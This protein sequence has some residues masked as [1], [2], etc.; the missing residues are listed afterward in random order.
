MSLLPKISPAVGFGY[1]ANRREKM[2][3]LKQEYLKKLRI[4]L[5][6]KHE[7]SK[8][9]E[10]DRKIKV[11]KFLNFCES[12]GV[13][14]IQDI[15]EQHFR[16][17]IKTL[18]VSTETKRKYLLALRE[19]FDRAHLEIAINVSRNIKS[20]KIKKL[21]KMIQILNIDIDSITEQQKNELLKL[22]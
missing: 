20:T 13:Q 10:Y 2:G 1:R 22:L 3:K 17:F 14:K 15:K 21:Q 11:L 9:S 8:K 18:N 16:E 5:R 7:T 19:F 12:Q 4:Y 6:R